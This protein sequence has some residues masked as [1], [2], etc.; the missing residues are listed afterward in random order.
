ML[1]W[2]KNNWK[3]LLGAV[4]TLG[5]SLLF[6]KAKDSKVNSDLNDLKDREEEVINNS[7]NQ[8]VE[9]IK[10]AAKKHS[11]D[12]KEAHNK[13]NN[14][15]KKAEDKKN[16]RKEELIKDSEEIDNELGKFGIKEVK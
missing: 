1:S 13:A 12:V 14:A 7:H 15:K 16:N 11:N 9:G 4:G 5:L 10:G 2:L 6:K 8:V 3:W